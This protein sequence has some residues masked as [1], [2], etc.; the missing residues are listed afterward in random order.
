MGG[1]SSRPTSLSFWHRRTSFFKSSG[2]TKQQGEPGNRAPRFTSEGS[3]RE[4]VTA[5][6]DHSALQ[7]AL[8]RAERVVIRTLRSAGGYRLLH[9][10]MWPSA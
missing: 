5:I 4:W 6:L 8:A 1:G 7:R 9:L 10:K 2:R 3:W